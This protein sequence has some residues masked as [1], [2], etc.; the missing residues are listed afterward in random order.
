MTPPVEAARINFRRATEAD[1]AF[2]VDCRLAMMDDIG[3]PKGLHYSTEMTRADNER[4]M[5]AHF[6]RDFSSWI[7]EIDGQGVASAGLIW[8]EHPPGPSN[9]AGREA[10]ILN[11]YTRPEAR[12]M[13]L[14]RALVERLIE[15]ARAAGVTRIWLRASE[16]GR[17]LN[18]DMGF[19][20]GSYLELKRDS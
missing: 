15:D 19:T 10:Y 3:R 2:L 1:L 13:G 11:V 4:W 6:G 9:P 16:A 20:A 12:R 8:H 5:A 18:E 17:P 14:A 7:A